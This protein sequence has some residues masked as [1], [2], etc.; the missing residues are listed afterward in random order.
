M[1]FRSSTYQS[2]RASIERWT[3]DDEDNGDDDDDSP[4]PE[5]SETS[6]AGGA[7]E[8]L[9]E[10][11]PCRYSPEST[12]FL[13]LDDGTRVRAPAELEFDPDVDVVEDDR[14]T[15]E[16]EEWPDGPFEI[17]GIETVV[18]HRRGRVSKLVAELEDR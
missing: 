12:E 3:A 14:V 11:V 16:G 1:T 9:S 8:L 6:D 18:D 17:L 13:R 10:G 2:A 4:F 5:T 15:L 7:W